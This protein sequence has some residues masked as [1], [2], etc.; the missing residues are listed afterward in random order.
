MKI[1]VINGPNMNM[2]GLREP[3]IYGSETYTDL[4]NKISD[5]AQSRDV[6]VKFFQSNHEGAIVDKIQNAL[7]DFDGIIINP[8]AYTHTSVAIRDALAAVNLPTAEVHISAVDS[9]E[10]FRRVNLV[11]D[12]CFFSVSGRG[13]DG[14]TEALDALIERLSK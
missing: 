11:R 4:V 5:Y 12:L 14:Y 7:G 2:L 8:A 10:D 13:T 1:L 6:S 3:E 9:R